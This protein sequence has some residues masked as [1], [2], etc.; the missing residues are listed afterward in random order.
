MC[1]VEHLRHQMCRVI[2]IYFRKSAH[3]LYRFSSK[4]INL[5]NKICHTC[6]QPLKWEGAIVTFV[7][8]QLKIDFEIKYIL[9]W[10]LNF[11]NLEN[12]FKK[13]CFVV[14]NPDLIKSF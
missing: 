3:I 4:I 13:Y 6:G 1:I 5:R 12:T 11:Q 10:P 2:Q 14:K 8:L 7:L 9:S